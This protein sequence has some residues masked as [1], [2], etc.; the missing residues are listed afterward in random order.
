MTDGRC[1]GPA[2][3]SP[4]RSTTTTEGGSSSPRLRTSP[5]QAEFHVTEA[6]FRTLLRETIREV[7]STRL[8]EGVARLSRTSLPSSRASSDG[9]LER[10]SCRFSGQTYAWSDIQ[11]G[12]RTSVVTGVRQ[13]GDP[14]LD[15][16]RYLLGEG[17]VA[18]LAASVAM[19]GVI[20]VESAG[21]IL[22]AGRGRGGGRDEEDV[23]RNRE[24]EM[25]D[26]EKDRQRFLEDLLQQTLRRVLDG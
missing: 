8:S 14:T 24:G 18:A 7:A 9:V 12:S 19:H 26:R 4:A 5:L 2:V 13:Y 1:A 3:G 10:W 20:P 16:D 23:V 21:E 25:E 17:N 11:R 6:D 22:R 15:M